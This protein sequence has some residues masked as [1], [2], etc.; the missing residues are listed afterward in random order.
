MSALFAE[1]AE[2]GVAFAVGKV[3]DS[4]DALAVSRA[5]ASS[6]SFE[7]FS[8]RCCSGTGCSK[9]SVTSRVRIFGGL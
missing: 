9:N 5:L 7:D 3:C 1:L 4:I 6:T 2:R 8:D